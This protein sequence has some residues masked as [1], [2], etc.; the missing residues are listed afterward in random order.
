MERK[1]RNLIFICVAV[2]ICAYI[3]RLSYMSSMVGIMEETG[4]GK[5]VAG[6]VSTLFYLAYGIGQFV[7]AFFCRRYNAR[8]VVAGSLLISALSNALAVLVR[9]VSVIRYIWFINGAAQSVLWCTLLE[10]LSHKLTPSQKKTAIVG[11]S[12]TT[13]IGTT[14]VYGL[15][16]LCIALDS[17]F[18]I[19]WIASGMLAAVALL[20]LYITRD[21]KNMPD[22]TAEAVQTE[23]KPMSVREVL[24]GSGAVII[25]CGIFAIGN[26]FL[27]DTMVTWVPVLLYDAFGVPGS[28]SVVITLLLPLLSLF[29]AL[30]AVSLHRRIP[31][32]TSMKGLLYLGS[33]VAFVGVLASYYFHSVIGTI[34][35]AVFNAC[36]MAAVTNIITSIIP[37]ERK[38]GAGLF[39]GLLDAFCYAGSTL[40]GF[41]PGMLIEYT[42]GF[43]S[44]LTGMPIF[45]LVLAL[46][47]GGIVLVEK[48]KL[49]TDI[50]HLDRK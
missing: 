32:Y 18:S 31:N 12:A 15:S 40:S 21:V 22:V 35:F 7:N 13:A 44:L 6:T 29:G 38:N 16:A 50:Y 47:A 10:L 3:G 19:F 36:L 41:L 5:D 33:T 17:T 48:K 8:G 37:L 27:R 26:G 39:A 20:W 1:A 24:K 46:F 49:H 23:S 11:M 4:A 42:G 43:G 9:D 34:V 28:F 25:C 30:L 2:Y 14:A 45:A